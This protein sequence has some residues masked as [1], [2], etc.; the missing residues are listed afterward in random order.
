MFFINNFLVSANAETSIPRV[1]QLNETDFIP[2]SSTSKEPAPK[3][4]APMQPAP[5]QLMNIEFTVIDSKAKESSPKLNIIE[6]PRSAS[7]ISNSPEQSPISLKSI[8][9]GSSEKLVI[10]ESKKGATS[11]VCLRPYRKI[12]D[13]T[14]VKRQP[15]T[16]W[17]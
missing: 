2:K 5:K 10:A 15:K 8:P 6:I 7:V 13:V 4:P 12:D 3:Q 9:S 1:D 16:G 14:T 17:L 11:P